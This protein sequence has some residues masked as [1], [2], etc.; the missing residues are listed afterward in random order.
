MWFE[1]VSVSKGS[2]S[3]GNTGETN[4]P[5]STVCSWE[6]KHPNQTQTINDLKD[7]HQRPTT[8]SCQAGLPAGCR[9][10]ETNRLPKNMRS[11]PGDQ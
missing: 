9:R 3:L 5:Q 4:N 8:L 11:H 2:F 6:M 7:E 10:C 1:P